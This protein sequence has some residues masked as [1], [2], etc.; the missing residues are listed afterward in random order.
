[1]AEI[2]VE[3]GGG[4][5]GSIDWSAAV[6]AGVVAG[7][8]FLVM[9]M[10]LA[11]LFGGA[12]SMWAPPRMIA[13]I[14]MG[15]GVLPPPADFALGP[16]MVAMLIHFTLSIAFGIVT[17]FI[18]RSMSMGAAI[19]VGIVLAL[20]L[21]VVVFYLMTPVWPWFANGRGWVAIVAHIA[22]GAVVA[23]WYR[24]RANPVEERRPA[25]A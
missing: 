22:F 12:P 1:M 17:A 20:L 11:P 25:A 4:S 15:E 23:W 24:A 10:M 5:T 19:G 13:A 6:W 3:R 9:E 2:A 14:A 21:Y 16:V 7:I 18:V 8:V